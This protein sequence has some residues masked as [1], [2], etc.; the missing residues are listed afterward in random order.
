M[1]CAAAKLD[2]KLTESPKRCSHLFIQALKGQ[3]FQIF[4]TPDTCNMQIQAVGKV[5]SSTNIHRNS[6]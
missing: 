1:L 3:F 6:V 5:L 2:Q 4:H